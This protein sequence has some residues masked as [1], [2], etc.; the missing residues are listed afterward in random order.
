MFSKNHD[1]MVLEVTTAPELYTKSIAARPINHQVHV[2]LLDELVPVYAMRRPPCRAAR[3]GFRQLIEHE[4][5]GSVVP[6]MDG[7]QSVLLSMCSPA[8]ATVGPG[9]RPG[10]NGS[11][12][13]L[14]SISDWGAPGETKT[15]RVNSGWLHDASTDHYGGTLCVSYPDIE[16]LWHHFYEECRSSLFRRIYPPNQIDKDLV[17]L[18]P[19]APSW[20]D[21]LL[22]HWITR[23]RR[24]RQRAQDGL[25][26][27][28]QCNLTTL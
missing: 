15:P 16:L 21:R 13:E 28:P 8:S 20:S 7:A 17:A 2:A 1:P 27:D 24:R 6:E 4:L 10:A 9:G 25:L 3:S 22:Q 18:F 23:R 5:V 26:K 19:T 12:S 11:W 14:W